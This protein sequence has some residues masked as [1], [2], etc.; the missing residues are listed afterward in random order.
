M[1]RSLEGPGEGI[2][3]TFGRIRA[4]IKEMSTLIHDLGN[5]AR[6]EHPKIE[7]ASL[8][9]LI[10]QVLEIFRGMPRRARIEVQI[11]APADL[12][13]IS[14]VPAQISQVI[15]NLLINAAQAIEATGRPEGGT[16]RVKLR[17]HGEAQSVE[18]TDDGIG[19]DPPILPKLFDHR[20]AT[21]A[22]GERIGLGLSIS[23]GIVTDHFG[24]IKVES[25]PGRGSRFRVFLPTNREDRPA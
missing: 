23:H 7:R 1:E 8:R 17:E 20:F 5:F 13:R 10:E 21:K 18:I 4:D 15:M 6:F 14:C 12:S 16:V 11:H 2:G 24:S 25:E 22:A 19:I 3:R 9:D